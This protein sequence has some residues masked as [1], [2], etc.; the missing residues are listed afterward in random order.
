M[1]V[2][3]ASEEADQARSAIARFSRAVLAVGE[4]SGNQHRAVPVVRY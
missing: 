4:K 1:H 3:F 2:L